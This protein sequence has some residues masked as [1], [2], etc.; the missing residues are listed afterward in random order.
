MYEGGGKFY[1][2]RILRSILA[3]LSLL[4]FSIFNFLQAYCILMKK[5]LYLKIN[6][7]HFSQTHN[8]S[9]LALRLCGRLLE[10]DV[11]ETSKRTAFAHDVWTKLEEHMGIDMTVDH[12]N[13][14]LAVYLENK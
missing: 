1:F 14:L 3:L 7:W 13:A 5:S 9:V 2:I 4:S 11:P 6:L 10:K 8:Q 12:Y